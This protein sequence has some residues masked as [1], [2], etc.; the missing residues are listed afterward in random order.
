MKRLIDWHLE[1]WKSRNQRKPILLKG[2]R[3]VGKTY[4]VRQLGKQFKNFIEIN[5]E[6]VPEAKTIFEKNLDPKRVIWE[7]SLLTKT[8]IIPGETL[9]FF[10]EIQA[11]PKAI[12][13]L[14]YF[15]EE[16]P[17]LHVLAAGSLID[18]AVEKVGMPVGRVNMLYVY[19]LSFLEFLAAINKTQFIEVILKEEHL[20]EII[21]NQLLDLLGQYLAI[22]GMPEAVRA[23]IETN[24][25]RASFEAQKGLLET[26]KLD[27]PKYA[28]RHQLPYLDILFNQI[29]HLIG[30]QFKYSA[31][32]GDYKKRELAPCLDLLCRA[33]VVHQVMHS[34]GNGLPLGAEVKLEWF[35]TLLLDVGLSQ[36]LLGLDLAAWFLNPDKEFVNRGLIA[37][38]FVG[39]ELLAYSSPGSRGNLYFWK[40]DRPSA[41]AEVDY[42]CE[43]QHQII[44]IEVKSG[45][46]SSLRSMHSFLSERKELKRGIRF[47]S[48]GFEI[49]NSIESKPLYAVATLANED[50]REA[51]KSLF[52]ERI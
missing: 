42:L 43:N 7:L 47:W 28:K 36:A 38:A 50:Q 22:G 26:Y 8:E 27:F 9:L 41:Q 10:D 16:M 12:T 44:P 3:Q 11:A 5:F 31:V 23:W 48:K 35:K 34:A 25:P 30:N 6:L 15:Y 49:T 39:Q 2:A 18:F 24:D 17:S 13:A 40:R 52:D 14:R 33:N 20:S 51:I 29:P 46:G 32:H 45:L 21:H 19:P 4:A 37:E 1:T